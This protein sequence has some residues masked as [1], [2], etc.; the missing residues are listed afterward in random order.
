MT[1]EVSKALP[2]CDPCITVLYN[3]KPHICRNMTIVLGHKCIERG[4]KV[5]PAYIF[6]KIREYISISPNKRNENFKTDRKV[7]VS[8]FINSF[9]KPNVIIPKGTETEIYIQHCDISD[10]LFDLYELLTQIPDFQGITITEDSLPP[11][12]R[13]GYESRRFNKHD[14]P[15]LISKKSKKH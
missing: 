1:K 9:C 4:E 14:L 13:D 8:R 12:L 11:K 6:D 7:P 3:E 5:T 10:K 15:L 2:P